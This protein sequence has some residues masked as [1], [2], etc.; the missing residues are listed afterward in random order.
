MRTDPLNAAELR[1]QVQWQ[2]ERTWDLERD[3]PWKI[4]VDASKFC[5]PLD[6][7]N[8]VFPGATLAQKKVLSQ[9][10]GLLINATIAEMEGVIHKLKD[11]A[12]NQ[13][14]RRNPVNPEMQELGELFFQEEQKHSLAFNRYNQIFCQQFGIAEEDMDRLMPKAFGSYFQRAVIS[15]AKKG[16]DAFWWVVA[17]VEEVSI[18]IYRMIHKF[19][20]DLDPLYFAIHRKHLEDESRHRNYA[21]LMLELI[22]NGR[23]GWRGFL[24][25]KGSLLLAQTLSSSW[26]LSELSKIYEVDKLKDAHPF[27]KELATCLPLLRKQHLPKI[28]WNLVV[29][30]PYISTVLNLNFHRHTMLAASEHHVPHFPLPT[31]RPGIL[32]GKA[33]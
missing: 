20:A 33:R 29:Q 30:A 1:Q 21:F 10:V 11:A 28:L 22:G 12:W 24:R 19:E 25:R 14:L 7:N 31:P 32:V 4:G 2:K 5:L 23:H 3:I 15:D 9:Y 26:V 16:G 18:E 17:S 27:F 8:I 13:V 6:D